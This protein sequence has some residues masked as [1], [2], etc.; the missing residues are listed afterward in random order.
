MRTEVESFFDREWR[1]CSN[2]TEIRHGAYGLYKGIRNLRM[3]QTC[4]RRSRNSAYE[5]N[6]R[7]TPGSIPEYTHQRE[8][9]H[10]VSLF[11]PELW[12]DLLSQLSCPLKPS[13]PS[14]LLQF[15]LHA[16]KPDQYIRTV[17]LTKGGK[18]TFSV[19]I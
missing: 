2:A 7:R 4:D 16:Q 1:S 5:Y 3:P 15:S 12:K 18:I 9:R 13:S 14:Q 10:K 6:Q 17:H 19:L 11:L 8:G